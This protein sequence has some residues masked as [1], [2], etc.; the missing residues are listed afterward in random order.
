[1]KTL[2]KMMA[3]VIAM[4]MVLA[5]STAAFAADTGSITI[6][7]S[8]GTNGVALTGKTFSAYKILDATYSG[9]GADQAVSY[10][11]PAEMID[12]FN[13]YFA[14]KDAQGNIVKDADN[15]DKDAKYLAD[16]AGMTL[17]AYVV[18]QMKD[19]KDNGAE[20]KKFE[21]AALT[22][23]KA[24]GI[25][26]IAGTVDGDNVKFNKLAAGYYIVEDNGTATPISALMLDT[27]TD[28]DVEIELKATDD[29]TKT[30][31]TAEELINSKA[32]E[33]GLGRA[34]NY[35]VTQKIPDYTGYD[36]YY[37]MINDTLSSGLTFNPESVVVKVIKPA[38]AAQYA[39]QDAYAD[40]DAATAAGY[41]QNTSA[42]DS[43][44]YWIKPATDAVTTELVEGTD[45]HLYYDNGAEAGDADY[46][47][48]IATILGGKTFIIA[49]HDIVAN[50]KTNIGDAVEVTYS[51]TVNS[52]AIVGVD[53]NN[54]TVNVTFS[55]N[56]DKDGKGDWDE[57]HPGI[58]AND[59]NH[60]TGEGPDKYTDTY[61]TKVGIVKIDGETEEAL[62]GVEFTLTGTGREVRVAA[63]EVFEIDPAGDY[64]L[65]TDGT[66]TKTAPQTAATLQETTGSAGWVEIAAG[67]TVADGTPIRVVDGKNYRPYVVATDSAKTRYVIIEP[68]EADYVSATTKYSKTVI[69][70]DADPEA[71]DYTITR[72]GITDADGKLDFSQL[73]AGTYKLSETGVLAGYNGIQDIEFTVTCTLPAPE[74]VVAGTEKATWAI[75]SNTPGVTFV[76]EKD[77]EDGLGTFVITIKNNKGTELPSTGGIGTTLFYIIGAIL[78]I[79]GGVVL[80]TRRRMSVR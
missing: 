3:L 16:A 42:T 72:T 36:Y 60:P 61:T 9:T 50:A 5:A 46:D 55:N 49:F 43:S 74:T 2:K 29:T 71:E 38:Q 54:N 6:K 1:M 25:P 14:E 23:A 13:D 15:K 17:D 59:G 4:V 56:P 35:K 76:E 57:D 24:A 48:Q 19:W 40:A 39:A 33:L 30:V 68:N 64:W 11:I 10:T 53:P 70:A 58:P 51:A 7:P 26:A 77:G 44:Q 69:A 8:T 65:L 75:T 67:E 18:E 28:S 27:V 31:M 63:Q 21:Y 12:F 45:Y 66:Y 80:I 78:V 52:D 37:Y 62:P 73:G 32:D 20:I 22:A 79:G 47:D 34:V 41:E